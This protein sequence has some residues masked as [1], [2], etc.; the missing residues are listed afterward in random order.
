[1]RDK[2]RKVLVFLLKIAV[3]AFLLVYLFRTK[4]IDLRK[5]FAVIGAADLWVLFGAFWLLMVGQ[6]LCS[7]RWGML[8]AHLGIRI[9]QWRLFQFYLIGMFFS[10]FFPSIIG[11]DVVKIFYVKRDSGRPLMYAFAA[12]YLERAAGFVALLGFGIAGSLY[13]PYALGAADFRPIG[14]LGLREVP[15]WA[16]VA[17]LTVLF[18]AAN[19]VLFSRRLYRWTVRLLERVRLAKLGGKIAQMGEAMHAFR[20][21]PAALVWPTVLSFVNIGMFITM[22]WLF[23]KALGLAVPFPVLAAIVSVIVVL[24][25]LP[26]SINGLGLR[27]T[28]F[29]VFLLPVVGDT[30]DHAARLV[31]LSLL[32]FLSAVISSLPGSLCYS[33]LK[34]ETA[35]D[36]IERELADDRPA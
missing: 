22:N 7:I 2:P 21:R 30:P 24:V 29:V 33:L 36:D 18:L 26:I 23:A 15:L 1:M 25:M 10:N 20:R 19:A 31:A 4:D 13:H 5:A 34:R 11:G 35:L 16:V 27:E 12:T 6:Y 17:A 28:A 9:R 8:L 14:W 3:T 32:N